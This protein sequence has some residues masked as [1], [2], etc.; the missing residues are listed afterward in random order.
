[1]KPSI[2]FLAIIALSGCTSQRIGDFTVLSTKNVDMS[3]LGQYERSGLRGEAR[4]MKSDFLWAAA[5]M[6]EAVDN[7]IESVPGCRALVDVTVKVVTRT[8]TSG[9][10]VE[11]ECLIDM[12]AAARANTAIEA[13]RANTAI[14]ID[15]SRKK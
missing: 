14:E 12:K 4:D 15:L 9:Y 1:M 5:S 7:V 10:E 3:E 11:G 8:F 2:A 13:A 6:E